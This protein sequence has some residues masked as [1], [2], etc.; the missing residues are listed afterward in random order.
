M[1]LLE[2]V[3][4]GASMADLDRVEAYSLCEEDQHL[5]DLLG[6]LVHPQVVAEVLLLVCRRESCCSKAYLFSDEVAQQVGLNISNMCIVA[7]RE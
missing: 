3:M 6:D 7:R 4:D 1:L 2:I 5:G